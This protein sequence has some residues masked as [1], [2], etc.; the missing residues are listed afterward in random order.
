M[1]ERMSVD[2]RDYL[3]EEQRAALDADS[4]VALSGE[5]Q[6]ALAVDRE[7][8]RDVFIPPGRFLMKGPVSI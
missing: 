5:L 8:G 7:A 3:S 2:L 6:I 4:E 1:G